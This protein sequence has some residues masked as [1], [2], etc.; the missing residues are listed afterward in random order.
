MSFYFLFF[1]RG[2]LST[3]VSEFTRQKYFAVV[4]PPLYNKK[5]SQAQLKIVA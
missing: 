1:L 2:D 3:E 5:L 4:G